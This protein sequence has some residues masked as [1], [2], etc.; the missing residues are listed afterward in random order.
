MR[1]PTFS[2]AFGA[3]LRRRRAKGA[4][5][6]R[7]ALFEPLEARE[8]LEIELVAPFASTP[9][10]TSEPTLAVSGSFPASRDVEYEFRWRQAPATS[11]SNLTCAPGRLDDEFDEDAD[12]LQWSSEIAI[13]ELFALAASES[14]I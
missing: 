14:K 11:W 8:L 2:R 6:T 9:L 3:I 4:P 13:P 10:A 7:R 5:P 12:E 1:T